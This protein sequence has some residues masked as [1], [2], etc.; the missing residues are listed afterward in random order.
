MLSKEN[1]IPPSNIDVDVID[2]LCFCF[3]WMQL[4]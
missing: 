4:F 1:I 2:D 3:I